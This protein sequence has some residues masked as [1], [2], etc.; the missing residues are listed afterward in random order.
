MHV[1]ITGA[2]QGI[3]R[4]LAEHYAAPGR[5]LT[6][7]GRAVDR[8]EEVAR[9]CEAKGAMAGI[10]VADVTD[11]NA[12]AE[13]LLSGDDLQPIDI[14]IA[15]AGVGGRDALAG[16]YGESPT[17]ARLMADV[18]FR[19]VINTIDPLMPRFVTRR[20]GRIAII[21]SL[22]GH[23][24]LPSCPAYSASKAAA[25]TYGIALD[26]LVRREGV[27]VSV[28]SPGF[29]KTAM[30]AELPMELPYL[31]SAERAA[32]IIVAGIAAGHREIVFPWQLRWASRFLASLPEALLLPILARSEPRLR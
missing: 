26:R 18:N 5:R 29:V 20:S 19:G 23:V 10:V 16:R 30:S 12:M 11:A 1:A 28:V 2:S 13:A 27:R 4:A 32:A 22:A 24:P 9:T 15:N 25:R 17:K 21:G 8:L 3:G 7:L 31:M 14:L 6:L